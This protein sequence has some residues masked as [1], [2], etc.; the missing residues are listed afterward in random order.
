MTI[1]E[2][3]VAEWVA[4]YVSAW[5]EPNEETLSAIFAA[6]AESHEW[7][8]ETHWEGRDEIL[9]GWLSRQQWQEG[10][11]TFGD[12]RLLAINGD[13]FAVQGI[14]RYTELGNFDN[15]WVVTLGDEGTAI[16]F[17]MW[18]NEV[19]KTA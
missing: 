19:S 10:G 14:G 1:T 15:L 7:P 4:G 11:W 16:S 13:T 18:N 2:Q 8:Y 9:E 12:W 3:Q 5:A 17:R 6:D